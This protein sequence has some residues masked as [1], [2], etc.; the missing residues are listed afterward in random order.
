MQKNATLLVRVLVAIRD[1][2]LASG[3]KVRHMYKVVAQRN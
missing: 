3:Q 2:V 1:E